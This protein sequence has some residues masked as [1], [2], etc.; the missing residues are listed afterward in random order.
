MAFG[1]DPSTGRWVPGPPATTASEVVDLFDRWRSTGE[2]I[3]LVIAGTTDDAYLG[4]V[5]IVI[6]EHRIGELGCGLVPSAQGRG[7]AAEAFGLF[8]RW[9]LATLGLGRL[10]VVIAVE[11]QPALRVAER[12]GFR[13]E[14]VLRSYLEHGGARFDAFMLSLLPGEAG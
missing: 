1:R 14:G 8:A 4:E 3:H 5:M 13:H 7:V 2:M 6:G 10:Q 11:N 12:A 9:C